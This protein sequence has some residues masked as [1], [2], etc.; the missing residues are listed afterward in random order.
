MGIAMKRRRSTWSFLF[1]AFVDYH[2]QLRY[3]VS[4]APRAAGRQMEKPASD[5]NADPPALAGADQCFP[6][7]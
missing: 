2:G 5:R 3:G 1:G 7:R 4:T 6:I